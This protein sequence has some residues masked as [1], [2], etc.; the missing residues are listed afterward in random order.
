MD[1]LTH[2]D[3][4]LCI[5]SADGQEARQAPEVCQAKCSDPRAFTMSSK[6]S[7]RP[8]LSLNLAKLAQQKIAGG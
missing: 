6:A 3:A 5:D 2:V 4:E 1:V 7:P 8:D